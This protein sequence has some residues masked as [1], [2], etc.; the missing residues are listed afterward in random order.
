MEEITVTLE[1]EFE[2]DVP[3][4]EIEI[5][6]HE[7]GFDLEHTPPSTNDITIRIR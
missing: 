7:S 1:G 6:L 2:V 3:E 4:H 5:V